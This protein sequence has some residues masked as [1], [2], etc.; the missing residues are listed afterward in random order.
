[1]SGRRGSKR[2]AISAN[3]RTARRIR[4]AMRSSEGYVDG[5]ANWLNTI[6]EISPH[7]TMPVQIRHLRQRSIIAN[8]V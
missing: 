7:E 5:G 3:T 2:L 4:P 8:P 6:I 1:M